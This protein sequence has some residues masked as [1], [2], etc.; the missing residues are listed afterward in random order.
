MANT[1]LI[2]FTAVPQNLVFDPDTIK[3]S[4]LVSP[5]LSGDDHLGPYGDWLNWT[6]RRLDGG[7]KL[8]FECG[9]NTLDV[10]ADTSGLRADLWGA[11]FNPRTL[12]NPYEFDDYSDRFVASYGVRTALGLLKATY[13]S[14][15]VEFAL[16]TVDGD[17]R[18]RIGRRRSRFES[19][20]NGFALDWSDEK[21][22][23]LLAEQRARQ[24]DLKGHL[25]ALTR[26]TGTVLNTV[27]DDSGLIVTGAL[28]PQSPAF[29]SASQSTVEQFG[30]FNHLPLGD[31][32]DKPVVLDKEKVLDFHQVLS[33]LGAYPD[34][35][36]KLGLVFDVELPLDF[37][38]QTS[39]TTPSELRITTA[40]GHWDPDTTTTVPATSTAY[41]HVRIGEKQLFGVAPRSM[42]GQPTG[43]TML[44][45]L[46]LDKAS[47]GVAQVDVDGAMH[48]TVMQADNVT[49]LPGQSPPQHPEVFDPATTLSSL[50]SGGFSL[51]ADARALT[52]LGTFNRSK[53]LN[54]DLEK[55]Q[56]QK[57]PF[58]AEDL[59]RGFRLDI[60]DSITRT[61]HSLHRKNTVMHIGEDKLE[62]TVQDEEG[63]FQPAATQA[64]PNAD[65]SHAT[66]DLYLHE[67]IVRWAGWSLSAATVGKHLTR[68][69]DPEHAVPDP[70]NPDPENE[71][72]T[73]FKVRSEAT[74]V[75]ASLPRLRFGVGYR[76]RLRQVDLAGNGLAIDDKAT[77]LLT[78]VFSMPRGDNVIA[79]LRFEPI[80]APAIVA[81]D[82]P[83]LTSEGSSNDRLVIRT[84]N[85]DPALDAAAAD[86]TGSERHIAPPGA[87][88]EFAERH[89]MFDD[90]G[91][92]LVGSP[93]MWKLISD[94]DLGT[95]H[96]EV[97]DEIVINGEKQ[98]YPVEGTAQINPLPYLP[99]PLARAAAFRNLPGTSGTTI[100]RA[101]PGSGTAQPMTYEPIPD[102]QPRPGTATI[103]EFGG[104][105]DWQQVKPFRL[106]LA[107]GSG[108]P[109]WDPAAALLTVSLPKGST[110]VVPISSVCDAEDLKLLGVWQWLREYLEYI[111]VNEVSSE[112]FQSP[113]AKDRIAH[114]LQLA[115]EGGHGML[116]PPHLLTFVHAVQQ[117]IGHPAFE[118]L[119]AQLGRVGMKVQ[120][121]PEDEPT[122]E[123]ELDVLTAWRVL[124][125]TD[126][127]LV[128][129][130]SVHGASTAKVDLKA[131]W[132]DPLD[133]P[134]PDASGLVSDPTEQSFSVQVDEVP[135]V[136][137]AGGE[138]KADGESRYVGYYDAE[139]DLVCFAP[140]GSKLGNLAEGDIV[141]ADSMPRH[142]IGDT[143][144]HVVSY[145]PLATSRYREYFPAK[146]GANPRDFTRSGEPVTVHVPAS[147]RPVAPSIRYVLP[148][149]GWERVTSGNQVRSVRT[150][151]GLRVYLDRP[152][153]SSGVGELLGVTL[154]YSGA[155]E[156]DRE[157]WKPFI[158]QWGQ[159]PI[160][161]TAALAD[162]PATYN[163][164]DATATESGLPLDPGPASSA[165]LLPRSVDVAG[166]EVHYDSNRKLYYCDLT[167]DCREATYAPFIRLALARYQPH[168]LVSAKLSRVVLADFAQLT[169]ERALMVTSDPYVP[170]VVRAV[171]SGPSP[172]GPLPHIEYPHGFG[173]SPGRPTKITVS[174]QVRDTAMNSDLAWSAAA[175][176]AVTQAAGASADDA[177]FI[178]W[179][180]SVRYTGSDA[181]EAGRYRLLITE[182]ELYEADGAVGQSLKLGTRLIYAE[183]VPLDESLL[184]A[185]TYPVSTTTL[186]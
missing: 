94:R 97:F 123:T 139:H 173:G 57:S 133:D 158:T 79:Y 177:D 108:S 160:W 74:H 88:V 28:D 45:L 63:W 10:D 176:F 157:E 134:T 66:T 47:F 165:Y 43:P 170:G 1:Q 35:Q 128:G 127:W 138:L 80:V 86:L 64:P 120:T 55:N 62:L 105:S 152:W 48:K 101:A 90:A 164:P 26:A 30:V 58:C 67:A 119:T 27:L 50:R 40:D 24:A 81:R 53:D 70:A 124:G 38:A 36:R 68:A 181:L 87:H 9:G 149:F 18:E 46:D 122:A 73:P 155:A 178:L 117:P 150:G 52:M 151:G 107:D 84:F 16:P 41:V 111:A 148:T 115:T 15:G 153:W 72:V 103:V 78:P 114:I 130:L 92:K 33:S 23:R 91:G 56:P 109:V 51:F 8:T 106:A 99:D 118:R 42:L 7:L 11:L 167:V 141:G 96:T 126:A 154:S 4:V 71:A 21:G 104:R 100:G 31:N 39:L 163:F 49:Q 125:S 93:A 136:S 113:A 161:Q 175:D 180:G 65:G 60:W 110:S 6:Q 168:A 172:R 162:F 95:F 85:T 156:P 112:F 13:Q 89:G 166:H 20:V 137:L 2:I 145:S 116:T 3:V 44:G 83:A 29:K 135:L 146:D 25:N 14:V 76:L 132:T 98:S 179:S 77:D 129:A 182:E 34:L 59:T 102:A 183:T 69:A 61:W 184:A 121:Q 186:A 144:H 17:P 5:R 185:P 32:A 37:L 19:F 22:T 143:R 171:V 169:P 174:V 159:D 75:K 54:A 131:S 82:A 147:A 140:S 142:Q 12:V